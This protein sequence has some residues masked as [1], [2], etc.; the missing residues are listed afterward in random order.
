MNLIQLARFCQ[1]LEFKTPTDKVTSF[2]SLEVID[3]YLFTILNL[4]YGKS[5]IAVKKATK[6]VAS[7]YG[8]FPDEIETFLDIY[9]DLGEAV[10]RFDGNSVD[11]ILTLRQVKELLELDCGKMDGTSYKIWEESF[12]QMSALEKKWFIRYW[13]RKPRNGLNTGTL[14]KA[15]AKRY[16]KKL[17]VVKRDC[18][19][20][21]L[22]E[23]V[24][25]Y[26]AGIEPSNK[27]TYGTFITPM[28]AKAAPKSKWWGYFVVDFKYDG[29][30]YQIHKHDDKVMIFNRRGK[31][32]TDQY[33][34]IVEMVLGWE[35]TNFIIDTEIYPI[36]EDGSPAPHQKLGTRVHKKNKAEA[37]AKCPVTLAV[38]DILMFNGDSLLESS[39]KTRYQLMHKADFN[40]LAKSW[41]SFDGGEHNM[42]A[43]YN[44]AINEG[45]EGIMIKN[46]NAI[47]QPGKRSIDWI[48][49]KPPQIELDVVIIGARYGQ[50]KRSDVF[51]SFDISV[52][53]GDDFVAL[54]SVGTGFSDDDL[55]RLT[56][57]LKPIIDSHSNGQYTLLPRVV[58]EVTSDLI[59][60]DENGN[61]GLRFPRCKRIRNDKP[62]SDINSIDDVIQM[63][64]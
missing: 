38:F 59:S 30:R 50:G 47:Y 39:Y 62:V 7:A 3:D 41:T 1:A 10:F 51:G 54:G 36:N 5:N 53:D 13:L 52:K 2:K 26:E 22:S 8:V 58:L 25:C 56:N 45:F 21:S 60:Q 33:P 42:I 23:V 9:G 44:Q 43:I 19:T 37:V 12:N 55:Y 34:D 57:Q 64:G 15:V 24:D 14:S 35:Q 6:W 28:L 31:I 27:L 40:C 29:N 46:A 48:K 32:T 16:V 11:S 18:N 61:Y 20:N 17:S 49:Y 4:E 63:R